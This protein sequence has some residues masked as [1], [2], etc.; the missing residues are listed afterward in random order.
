MKFSRFSIYAWVLVLMPFLV[1]PSFADLPDDVYALQQRWA[2]VNYQL[3]GDVRV[4]AYQDLI[5]QAETVTSAN[6]ESA[7]AWI[8]SGIIKSSFAGIKGGLGALG[9]AKA[10][11]AD[12]ERAM[13]LDAEAMN[14]SAYTS[15]GVLYMNV[16][17]WPVGF[18]DSDK[19]KELLLHAVR[20]APED[21][22][23]NYFMAEYYQK[24]KDYVLARHYLDAAKNAPA[25]AG[26]DVADHGRHGEIELM[27]LQLADKH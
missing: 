24:Q 1:L 26:R 9:L 2:E 18:G 14:G 15:L 27:L 22:D 13:A 11:K 3:Q 8:W 20:M 4:Q 5:R 23:A 12:L 10:A 17:G 16:P 21:I 19:A 25:R 7:P 6:P